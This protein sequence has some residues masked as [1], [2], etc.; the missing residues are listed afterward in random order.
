MSPEP[1]TFTSAQSMMLSDSTP[2]AAIHYTTDGTHAD[3]RALRSTANQLS[4]SATTTIHA[5]AAAPGYSSSAIVGGTY[6]I[7][8]STGDRDRDRA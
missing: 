4:V 5:L 3:R 8:A 1:G 7:S 2:G 6:T